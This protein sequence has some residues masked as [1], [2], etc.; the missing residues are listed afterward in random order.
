M[1][2]PGQSSDSDRMWPWLLLAL[3]LLLLVGF[4]IAAGTR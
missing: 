2:D 3:S 4:A 1:S